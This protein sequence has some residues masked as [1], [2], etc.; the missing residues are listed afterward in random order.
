MLR[1]MACSFLMLATAALCG[2][3][4]IGYAANAAAGS[5]RAPAKYTLAKRP[6]IVI[7]EKYDNPAD[8][9][10]DAEPLARYVTEQLKAHEL[11]PTVDPEKVSALKQSDPARFR[12][13]T[14]AALGRAVDAEQILYLNIVSSQIEVAEGSDMIR[15][16]G[17]VR[18]R[19]VDAG[20]GATL[21][22]T[23]EAAGY[24]IAAQTRLYRRD[25]NTINDASVR[26]ELLR[27][28]AESVGRLFY[29]V[30]AD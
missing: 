21:W 28:L 25:E 5:S 9:V 20:T 22:P 19:L 30:R 24:T 14:I 1:A 29:K 12:A 26:T 15:G 11:A 27:T 17:V 23:S 10:Y 4:V 18:V 16:D 7:A 13:L 3:N 8:V 6:T 2:C